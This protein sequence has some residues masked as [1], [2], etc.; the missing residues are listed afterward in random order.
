MREKQGRY[1]QILGV[2]LVLALLLAGCAA[3]ENLYLQPGQGLPAPTASDRPVVQLA[4]FSEEF[5][6]N[7]VVGGHF[8]RNQ[9]QVLKIEEG[10]TARAL[11]RLIGSHLAERGIPFIYGE[12]W[13]GAITGLERIQPPV[14]LVVEGRISRLWLEVK[15]GITHTNYDIRLDVDCRLGVVPDKKVIS[16]TVHVSEEVIK[17]SSQPEEMEKLLDKSLAEAARQIALKIAEN[18]GTGAGA[19][20]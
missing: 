18:V 15:S 14:R 5:G 16:R 11:R 4:P 1:Q 12:E 6:S 10:Q 3:R 20:E 2:G 13:N 9:R 19:G 8:F 7:E 17:F